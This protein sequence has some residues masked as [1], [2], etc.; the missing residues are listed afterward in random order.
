MNKYQSYKPSGVEW[1]GEIP[2][3]W[4]IGRLGYFSNVYRGSGYQYL[5]QV[6]DDFEKR[7]ERV[8][9]I[10]DI[11]EFNPIW[12]EYVEQFENYRIKKDEILIGGTGHYFGKSIYVTDEMEG[13]IHSYNIIRLVVKNQCSKYIQYYLSSPMIREQMD[14]SVLGSGQPFID[15]QGLKDLIILI[16]E[17]KE[18]HQIVQFLDSKTELIDKL[19]SI[20]E[21][22]IS[23]LKEQRT[24]LINQVVTKGLNPKVEMKDSGVEWF[25][26]IP[27]HWTKS[28]VK[29]VSTIFGRIGYRGYT[30]EDIVSEGEGVITISPSNIKNDIFTIEGENTFLSYEKYEESPEIQIFTNDIILVKTGSTIGK[31]S[32]IPCDV[33]KMTINP[34]LVVLKELKIDNKYFYYQTVC[35][36]FKKSFLVEQTGSTTPTISQE[37]INGFPILIPSRQEQHQIVEHLDSKTKEIDDLVQLEQK[38]IDILKEY[39]QSLISEVVTGKIKVTTDE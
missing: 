25:G 38:K 29:Y 31:T 13:L 34:Q 2:G 28:K 32:I 9:R 3:G 15:L 18:Q 35:E 4:I 14:M 21:Q 16:P 12:C 23:L 5:N 27:E 10:G 6:E 20:K 7:K 26:K 22:K 8:V 11:S 33:P 19:V 24:S 30:V 36:Y 17:Y 39:R 37:K 1:I